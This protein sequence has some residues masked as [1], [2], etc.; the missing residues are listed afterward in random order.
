MKQWQGILCLI[1]WGLMLSMLAHES[2]ADESCSKEVVCVEAVNKENGI[3]FF[4]KNLQAA[5]I[6]ITIEFPEF[7]NLTAQVSFPYTGTYAGLKTT[8][9]FTLTFR[10]SE[11]AW[12]YRYVYAWVWGTPQATHD[13]A[14]VYSLPYASGQTYAVV[15]GVNP[16]PEDFGDFQD[17]WAWAMPAGTPVHATRSGIVVGVN[18]AK[19]LKNLMIKHADGTLGQYFYLQAQVQVG[20]HVEVGQLL[21]ASG[22]AGDAAP[23][24]LLFFVHK[25]LDGK[26]G[27]SFPLRFLTR[28][29]IGVALEEGQ[30]YTAF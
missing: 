7:E 13:N 16:V 1:C 19:P 14:Y 3:D 11:A 15:P 29:G 27:Q 25:A 6:T 24:H 12:N 23:P 5:E 26:H 8:N 18:N 20:Q 21:G 30:A 2:L 22:N 10:D 4:V 17:L 9:A 28:E